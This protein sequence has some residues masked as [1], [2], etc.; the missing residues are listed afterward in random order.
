[1]LEF[2]KEKYS[3]K[4]ENLKDFVIM[5]F[6]LVSDLYKYYALPAIPRRNGMKRMVMSDVEIITIS[7]T[8][9][10]MSIDSERAWYDFC[11]KNLTDMS[12]DFVKAFLKSSLNG[13]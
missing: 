12:P 1:M 8:G 13:D 5:T 10:L 11:R 9:E 7:I 3:M 4:I 2:L 6:V